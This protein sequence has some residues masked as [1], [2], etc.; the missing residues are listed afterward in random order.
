MSNLDSIS[1]NNL[2]STRIDNNSIANPYN[3]KIHGW[4]A[5]FLFQ[6]VTGGLFSIIF[7]LLTTNIIEYN[8]NYILA[9]SPLFWGIT[10]SALATY[11]VIA[12]IKKRCNAVFLGKANMIICFVLYLFLVVFGNK[13]DAKTIGGILG[14]TLW[15]LYLTY[16]GQVNDIFP[17][18]YRK[19][20]KRDYYIIAISILLPLLFFCVGIVTH[21]PN[22]VKVEE[23]I[24]ESRK[25]ASNEL[26]DERIIFTLP[27]WLY[28]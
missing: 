10:A 22:P 15:F 16:S 8:Y 9:Y 21:N 18:G 28:I 4:L 25:L 17:K 20:L 12:F 27:N 2:N 19:A 5:F 1:P 7:P 14:C 13:L 23:P 3:A 11:T 26:T 24:T 6:L